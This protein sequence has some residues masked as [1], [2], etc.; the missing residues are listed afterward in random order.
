MNKTAKNNR[1][2]IVG[3]LIILLATLLTFTVVL[4]KSKSQ[5]QPAPKISV[6]KPITPVTDKSSW[7]TYPSKG[8]YVTYSFM[9]PS[10]VKVEEVQGF[11]RVFLSDKTSTIDLQNGKL[12]EN[13]TLQNYADVKFNKLA[14]NAKVNGYEA[15][16]YTT[17]ETSTLLVKN[18][19]NK[20]GF[21]KMEVSID[22]KNKAVGKEWAEIF[23]TFKFVTE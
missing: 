12:A 15:Y 23:S 14:K 10:D 2:N 9:Y 7:K 19:N 3:Y 4:Y 8:S 21:V 11:T 1:G 17:D 18:P 22:S 20:I 16:E 13:Q 5:P 6:T